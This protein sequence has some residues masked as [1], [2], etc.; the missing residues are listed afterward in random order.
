MALLLATFPSDIMSVGNARHAV[1][2]AL[3]GANL[4]GFHD[5]ARLVVDELVWNVVLHAGTAAVVRVRCDEA[6]LLIEVGDGS[7]QPPVHRAAGPDDIAGRGLNI[8][9][10][11]A[12]SWGWDEFDDGKV[13]WARLADPSRGL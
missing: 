3:T 9:D 1:E 5:S 2:E 7:R 6:T 13:V 10:E 11:L 4:E 8:V 12:D